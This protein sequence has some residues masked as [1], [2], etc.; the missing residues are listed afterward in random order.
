M[1]PKSQA[2]INPSLPQYPFLT[3]KMYHAN[4]YTIL[5][6][7]RIIRLYSNA[8]DYAICTLNYYED[9]YFISLFAH[10]KHTV[11]IYAHNFTHLL[12]ISINNHPLLY[13][14]INMHKYA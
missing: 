5:S 11:K 1:T 3:I 6:F 2:K 4:K 10:F 7:N 8:Y 12:K 9:K 13:I 14:H